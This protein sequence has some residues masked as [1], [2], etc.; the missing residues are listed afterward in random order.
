M[1]ACRRRP[2]SAL[3]SSR[4]TQAAR[5]Q[6]RPA[7]DGGPSRR[8]WHWPRLASSLL[9]RR[10]PGAR[11]RGRGRAGLPRA[12]RLPRPRRKAA[13]AQLRQASKASAPQLKRL[14]V[15][16]EGCGADKE[17]GL[18]GGHLA[19]GKLEVG[20]AAA[21]VGAEAAEVVVGALVQ[22]PYEGEALGV[23]PEA[24][25]S[26]PG[27]RGPDRRHQLSCAWVRAHGPVPALSHKPSKSAAF[28]TA[29]GAR[30]SSWQAGAEAGST[31]MGQVRRSCQ[32]A[33]QTRDK[34]QETPAAVS[35][36][37]PPAH[38]AEP[39]QPATPAASCCCAPASPRATGSR[40]TRAREAGVCRVASPPLTEVMRDAVD[41]RL[42][43][44]CTAGHRRGPD[45]RRKTHGHGT[46]RQ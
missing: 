46:G 36:R 7:D 21:H 31:S 25:C 28:A 17:G 22:L 3:G 27:V 18:R 29:A 1:V 14:R 43:A 2:A 42:R 23:E 15:Q 32:D 24:A 26:G 45:S 33:R 16:R 44:L 38:A 40:A 11:D 39:Q 30:T 10:P 5:G 6:R 12:A 8:I 37:P 20:V 41:T 4:H 9:L 13:S 19:E 34:R 35:R